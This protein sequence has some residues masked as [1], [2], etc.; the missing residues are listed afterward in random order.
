MPQIDITALIS[1]GAAVLF[2]QPT[3]ATDGVGLSLPR[4]TLGEAIEIEQALAEYL[5]ST[6]GIEVVEQS[7]VDTLYERDPDG[8]VRLNNLQHVTEWAG[9]PAARAG[10]QVPVWMPASALVD[11]ELPGDLRAATLATLGIAAPPEPERLPSV[12]AGRVI[13]ITG[14]AGAGKSSVAQGVAERLER[15]ALVALDELWHSVISGA[16]LPSWRGGDD[17]ETRRFVDLTLRNAAALARNFAAAGFDCIVEGVLESPAELDALLAGLGPVET[18]FVTLAPQLAE[19]LQRDQGRSP[20]QQMGERS[21]ELHAILQFNGEWRG[22][23]VDSTGLSPA[24]TADLILESLDD[25]R[26]N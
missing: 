17:Y 19:L 5:Q 20:E 7:F 1:D 12:P 16:P 23:R 14:A 22:M 26:V 15:S 21:A 24:E 6:L 10:G 9:A 8:G 13:V 3:T 4:C 11:L 2:L 25:A 18:Y